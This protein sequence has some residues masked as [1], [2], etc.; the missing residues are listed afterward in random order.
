MYSW[1]PLVAAA[2]DVDN[3]HASIA[4]DKYGHSV[5]DCHFVGRAA[6]AP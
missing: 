1:N 6:P 2:S 3:I 4:D 5:P